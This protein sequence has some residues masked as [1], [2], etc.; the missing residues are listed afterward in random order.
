MA[1]KD[2][3]SRTLALLVLATVLGAFSAMQLS[4]NDHSRV[5]AATG[6][7]DALN[8]GTCLATDADVFEDENCQLFDRSDGWEIRDEIEEVSTLYATY[9]HD[10][11]AGW[12][13]PRAIIEDS[14]LLKISVLDPGR[15]R[16][17][18]VL[19]RGQ[20]HNE[21]QGGL[22]VIKSELVDRDLIDS[23]AAIAFES[24]TRLVVQR[25]AGIA[26]IDNSGSHTLNFDGGS[27]YKPMDVDGNIR[28]FGCVTSASAC[29]ATGSGDDA[30]VDVTSWI[31]V[32]E[33]RTSGSTNPDIA[34]WMAVNASVPASANILI[35]AVYYETSDREVMIGDS[36]YYYCESS[37]DTPDEDRDGVWRCGS[38][39]AKERNTVGDVVFAPREVDGNDELLLRVGSNGDEPWVNLYLA[40][41]GR[42]TGRYEGYVRLTDANGDGNYAGSTASSTDWGARVRDGSAGSRESDAAVIGVASGPVYIEYRDSGGRR[43]SLRIAIDYEPPRIEIQEPRHDSASD[44]H[45]PDFIGTFFDQDSGLAKDSFRLVVDNDVDSPGT[46][47]SRWTVSLRRRG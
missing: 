6:V 8:V 35:Y 20:G 7:I 28:F 36:T 39:E 31:Q 13:E 14:D 12:D 22:G 5:N 25:S 18:A 38:K 21:L 23:D 46:P 40:E 10:P 37:N 29:V 45:S 15:D 11:K 2:I 4:L 34:P 43:Q 19:V 42:F 41:T 24:G 16:R 32:D 47:I 30:L 44:D 33:D 17:S 1:T 27:S 3:R 26:R 9:A